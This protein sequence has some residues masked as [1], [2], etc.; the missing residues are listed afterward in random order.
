MFNNFYVVTLGFT[1]EARGPF[2]YDNAIKE[3]ER[4][5]K[6]FRAKVMVVREINSVCVKPIEII[7]TFDPKLCEEI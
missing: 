7:W 4:L 3:A 5:S 1:T 6:H 2:E